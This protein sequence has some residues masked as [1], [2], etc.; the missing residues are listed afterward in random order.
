MASLVLA[1][2]SIKMSGRTMTK[3][4]VRELCDILR[5]MDVHVERLCEAT[6]VEENTSTSRSYCSKYGM[7]LRTT[8]MYH[9]RGVIFSMSPEKRLS[10]AEPFLRYP[11]LITL[12]ILVPRCMKHSN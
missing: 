11:C 2:S 4:Q 12:S 9:L 1:V 5:L 6:G 7:R 8:S 3:V 10:L